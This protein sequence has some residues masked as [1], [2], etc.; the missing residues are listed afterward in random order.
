ML[1]KKF[2]RI[3]KLIEKRSIKINGR[4]NNMYEY[5]IKISLTVNINNMANHVN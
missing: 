1:E 5:C 3:K 4:K 2:E